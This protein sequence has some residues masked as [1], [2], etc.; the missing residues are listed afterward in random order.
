MNEEGI[1][2]RAKEGTMIALP[3]RIDEQPQQRFSSPLALFPTTPKILDGDLFALITDFFDWLELDWRLPLFAKDPTREPLPRPFDLDAGPYTVLDLVRVYGRSVHTVHQF[4]WRH[5]IPSIGSRPAE[6]GGRHTLYHK[7]DLLQVIEQWEWERLM[8]VVDIWWLRFF[9]PACGTCQRCRTHALHAV[10][11]QIH[12]SGSVPLAHLRSVFHQLVEEVR[13]LGS[14]AAWWQTHADDGWQGERCGAWGVILIYLLDRRLLH[15]S[16]DEMIFLKPLRDRTYQELARLWRHRC[17]DEYAQFQHALDLAQ[18]HSWAKD[19]ALVILSLLVLLK[20]GLTGLADLE[21]PLLTEELEQ[22]CRDKRLVTTHVGLGF[23]LPYP[24]HADIR[25]GHVALDDIRNYLWQYAAKQKQSLYKSCWDKG[26]RHFHQ[27]A[28]G[29]IEQAL[30]APVYKEQRGILPR[31]PETER[32]LINPHRIVH[33]GKLN[34]AGY[35]LLPSEVQQDVMVYLTYRHQEEHEALTTLRAQCNTLLHFFTWARIQG[36]LAGYPYWTRQVTHEICRS[37]AVGG[38]SELLAAT[39]RERFYEL[40]HFFTTLANLERPVPEGYRLLYT[41]ENSTKDAGSPRMLPQEAIMD[42]V[43]H[44]GVRQLSYDPFA[45][46]AL[47]IQYYCGTRVTETCDLHVFCILEDRDGHAYLLIPKGK[48]KEER[49]FPIVELG[50]GPLLEYMDEIVALRLTPEGTPRN[51]GKT[52]FRYLE[53]DPEKARDWHYLFDRVSST[54]GVVRRRGRLS[55]ARV[56]TALQEALLIAAHTNPD[57]LLQMSTYQPVCHARRRKG[58]RC[59]YFAAKEGV[60]TCPCCRSTLAGHL[61]TR[62]YHTLEA[63]FVCDGVA[64]HGEFFC[65]KC[66]SPLAEFVP[67]TT[68]VFRHNSVS[69]AHRAG[70]SLAQNMRLH[71]HQTV[72]M[73]LRY[74]H[75]LLEDTTNEVRQ[76]FAEK[77]LRDVRQVLGTTAGKIIEGGVAYTASLEHYLGITLQRALKRRTYGVWGGFWAGALAQRGI[78]SPLSVEVEIVIPEDTYEHT[79]AQYWYE[80]LGL[81]VSEVAF[82]H[83]TRGKWHAEVSPFLDRH[84]IEDLVQFH[85]HHVQ[86]SLK[87]ALGQ[88]LMETDILEQRRFLDDLAEKLR[89][90]W[91]HLGTIDQLVEMFAPGGGHAFQKQLPS[92]EP[93]S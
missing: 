35:Q 15:L 53:D 60:T 48:T 39:R 46:L 82:E 44:D 2:L 40:A 61:G 86:D 59:L 81:A 23:F 76:I 10:T 21:R 67:I 89:P 4:L 16:Y 65:P 13:R 26:P 70:V 33:E 73:H 42:R 56:N 28:T 1:S 47:T 11:Q 69:R 72:P 37:Y 36:H 62:C 58:Q 31:R 29:V 87:S 30:A 75:L 43:F 54:D 68:H 51:L 85:L 7:Q 84:K 74:L 3:Q 49:P 9:P 79:V 66:D 27:G 8:N 20:H 17:P 57:G 92:T 12:C 64:Q 5:R 38:C 93:A 55:Y 41:L 91:Q 83:V 32:K 52:N 80:A 24:L 19:Q 50:M 25:V 45:R 18:Y 22:V 14:I 78:A 88:R 71:G 6:K 77:R 90:W 63:D 34:N